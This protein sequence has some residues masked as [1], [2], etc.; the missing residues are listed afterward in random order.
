VLR[1]L[2]K[3]ALAAAALAAL[4]QWVPVADRTLAERW[5][6]ARG[7]P[8]AFAARGWDEL[9]G[10][11]RPTAPADGAPQARRR[12]AGRERPVERHTE[13]DRRALDRLLA[14]QL[15]GDR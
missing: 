8:A 12:Q 4:W 10:A 13:A 2:A 1:L 3:L 6:A 5:R 15:D 14:E 9:R 7:D 11:R